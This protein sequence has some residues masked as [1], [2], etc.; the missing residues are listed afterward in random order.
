MIKKIFL[1]SLCYFLILLP[2]ISFCHCLPSF[3]SPPL[4]FFLSNV[5]SHAHYLPLHLFPSVTVSVCLSLCSLTPSFLLSLSFSLSIYLSLYL[6]LPLSLYLSLTLSSNF[7]SLLTPSN[8]FH[9]STLL[10][11]YKHDTSGLIPHFPM[12]CLN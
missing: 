3:L 4:C 7:V 6:S 8:G 2:I 11:Y 5:L 9:I 1:H 10:F 12:L